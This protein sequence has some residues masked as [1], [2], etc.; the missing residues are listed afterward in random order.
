M[1]G[2]RGLAT[3]DLLAH[4]DRGEAATL[5]VGTRPSCSE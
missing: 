4:L 3:P 5:V 2:R 1:I